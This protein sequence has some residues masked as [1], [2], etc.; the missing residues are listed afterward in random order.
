V[1]KVNPHE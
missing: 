1:Y